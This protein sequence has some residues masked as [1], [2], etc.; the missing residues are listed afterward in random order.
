[1]P[2]GEIL[3]GNRP[4][5]VHAGKAETGAFRGIQDFLPLGCG[6]EFALVVKE[7]EGV[8]LTRVVRCREYDS[9]VGP[10]ER[11]G[12][13]SGGSG[14]KT[15]FNDV[16]A[17]GDEG[18]HD[19][20]LHHVAREPGILADHDLVPGSVRSGLPVR[21]GSR[22]GCGE[23]DD[24]NRCEGAAGCPPDGATDSGNRFNQCH[25]KNV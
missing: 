24:V 8:P 5:S 21:Q 6:E 2:V 13:L 9:A 15:A 25:V 16:H 10:G 17:T 1:M 7:F 19:Y 18:T 14:S 4:E 3:L 12:H 20:L 22:I 11:D 23:L